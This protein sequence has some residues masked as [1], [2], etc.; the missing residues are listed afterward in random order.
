MLSLVSVFKI[1]LFFKILLIA[2]EKSQP[3][4]PMNRDVKMVCF[5]LNKTDSALFSPVSEYACCN[6]EL[7]QSSDCIFCHI[8]SVVE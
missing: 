7:Y 3:P 1:F 8:F 2:K 4:A 5:V 6:L